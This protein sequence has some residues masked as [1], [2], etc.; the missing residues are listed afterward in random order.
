MHK[1]L[2]ICY[3]SLLFL[4][5]FAPLCYKAFPSGMLAVGNFISKQMFRHL[6]LT[7]IYESKAP[8]RLLQQASHAD[9]CGCCCSG[10]WV[11]H[12]N[13][14]SSVRDEIINL[15]RFKYEH[16]NTERRHGECRSTTRTENNTGQKCDR[17]H[18]RQWRPT[19]TRRREQGY[20]LSDIHHSMEKNVLVQQTAE[21]VALLESA[22]SEKLFLT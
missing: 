12:A 20:T 21:M 1:V 2:P 22:A 7:F 5:H 16:S 13:L 15:S 6:T 3:T 14:L 10:S 17:L 11:I 9:R 18:H 19:Q 8:Q 4:P